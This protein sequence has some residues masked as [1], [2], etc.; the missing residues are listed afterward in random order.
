MKILFCQSHETRKLNEFFE[1][2]KYVN[3]I[4]T[5]YIFG[6]VKAAVMDKTFYDVYRAPFQMKHMYI[7]RKHIHTLIESTI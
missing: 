3:E 7:E 1:I 4:V 6:S 5:L 2:S